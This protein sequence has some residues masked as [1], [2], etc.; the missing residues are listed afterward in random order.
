MSNELSAMEGWALLDFGD[1]GPAA[2]ADRPGKVPDSRHSV[3]RRAG[4]SSSA[5]TEMFL[6]FALVE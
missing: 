1:F 5:M 2:A 4:R 3:K 6:S